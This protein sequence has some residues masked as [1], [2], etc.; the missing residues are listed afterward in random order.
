MFSCEF[1]EISRDTC[2]KELFRRL[3]LHKN[4]FCLLYHHDLLLFQKRCCICFPVEYFLSLICRLETRE[5]SIFQT[6]SQKLKAYF[7]SVD[8][9]RFSFFC[10]N[11]SE[12]LKGTLLQIPPY[13][14]IHIKII[15]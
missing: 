10:K 15:L 8:H 11:S 12:Q 13:V 6:L 1:C 5:S 9:P 3:V 2:F 14:Q 4:S 7:Y